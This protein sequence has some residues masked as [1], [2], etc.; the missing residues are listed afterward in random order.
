MN[1]TFSSAFLVF[2]GGGLGSLLRWLVGLGAMRI[3]GGSFPYGTLIVNLAGCLAMGLLA[4]LLL[5]P[6]EA[7]G[8]EARLLLM[9][10]VL[11][12]FTTFSAFALDVS[13]LWLRDA[14]GL[15]LVYIAASVLGSLAMVALGL[16]LGG[17]ARPA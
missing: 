4:R 14:G 16:W 13:Q 6:E 10:G 2:L 9:T 11:G 12:G 5:L 15:A 7:G 8:N 1:L 17:M 3:L